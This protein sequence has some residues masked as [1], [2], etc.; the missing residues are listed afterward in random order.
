MTILTKSV[1]RI[2]AFAD[3]ITHTDGA[4]MTRAFLIAFTGIVALFALSAFAANVGPGE[5][6]RF[7]IRNFQVEGNTLIAADEIEAL[8][9]P[10]TGKEKDFGTLQEAHEALE[11]AYRSRGF[12]M[13]VVT[14]PEQ[15]IEKGV[16]HLK[17]VEKRIGKIKC[18][19]NSNKSCC[20]SICCC[21][22]KE[23]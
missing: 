22:F 20:W 8:L 1:T 13:V 15:E 6:P 23:F 18:K 17:V 14:L 7:E 10:F 2:V 9:A 19:R 21:I 16:I 4:H 12:Y 3:H 5:I 11:K